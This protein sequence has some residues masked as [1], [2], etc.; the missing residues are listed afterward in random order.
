MLKSKRRRT[1]DDQY[2]AILRSLTQEEQ[3]ELFAIKRKYNWIINKL[4]NG[5]PLRGIENDWL[6]TRPH[7]IASE[8]IGVDIVEG[9]LIYVR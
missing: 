7:Y 5:I 4:D 3:I 8:K 1:V 2:S 6:Q 9:E